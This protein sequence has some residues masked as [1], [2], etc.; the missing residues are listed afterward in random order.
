LRPHG[1]IQRIVEVAQAVKGLFLVLRLGQLIVNIRIP[2]RLG[3]ELVVYLHK[4]VGEQFAVRD[5]LHGV[6]WDF[7]VTLGF[8]D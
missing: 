8:L 2:Q 5:C 3:K 6:P 4:P 7:T 1:R